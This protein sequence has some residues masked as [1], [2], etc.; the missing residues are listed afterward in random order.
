MPAASFT[1]NRAAFPIEELAKYI[2]KWVAFSPDGT[3]IIAAHEDV[4]TVAQL[5]EQAGFDPQTVVFE[6]FPE[7]DT[8]YGGGLQ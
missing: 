2:G 8:I 6:G 3:K 5:V 7:E 4:E 1:K